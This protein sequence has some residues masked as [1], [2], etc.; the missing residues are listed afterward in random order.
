MLFRRSKGV[1]SLSV[2]DILLPPLPAPVFAKCPVEDD[3]DDCNS[4]KD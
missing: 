2:I 4:D 3:D 1:N